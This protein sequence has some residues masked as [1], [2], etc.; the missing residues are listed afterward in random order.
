MSVQ[1]QRSRGSPGAA[2]RAAHHGAGA[3]R[4][5]RGR[6]R[7]L[8]PGR[9]V[10]GLRLLHQSSNQRVNKVFTFSPLISILFC[11][12]LFS[13]RSSILCYMLNVTWPRASRTPAAAEQLLVLGSAALSTGLVRDQPPASRPRARLAAAEPRDLRDLATRPRH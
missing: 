7:W 13:A 1:T 2:A 3:G 5:G 12:P 6:L 8:P 4:G 11:A 10:R 9:G